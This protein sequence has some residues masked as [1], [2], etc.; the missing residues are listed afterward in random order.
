MKNIDWI[1][2]S[3]FIV[4]N[5]IKKLVCDPWFEGSVFNNG[6]D[7]LAKTKHDISIFNDIDYIWISHEHPDHFDIQ[8][9]KKIEKEVR[10]KI[11][12]IFQF[13]KDKRVINF[14]K[15]LGFKTKELKIN[16]ELSLDKNFSITIVGNYSH[17]D[18][19][20]LIKIDDIKILNLNDCAISDNN[21]IKKLKN[22]VK[23][24]DVLMMQFSYANWQGDKNNI[25]R[26]KKTASK[27]KSSLIEKC[28][29]F[30][31]NF[32]F[33]FASFVYFSH[34]ENFFQNSCTNNISEICDAINKETTSKPIVLLPGEKWNFSNKDCNESI[35]SY[36]KLQK[37]IYIKRFCTDDQKYKIDLLINE[38]RNYLKRINEKH[39]LKRSAYA[40]KKFS[41]YSKRNCNIFIKDL[42]ASFYFD[43]KNGLSPNNIGQTD[44]DI[45]LT[46]GNLF[47][48]FK[49]D[50]GADTLSV[51]GRFEIKDL[52]SRKRVFSTFSLGMKL[53][54]KKYLR[55]SYFEIFTDYLKKKKLFKKFI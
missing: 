6:W 29:I 33:P 54:T 36:S 1:N 51:N 32:F 11:T 7:L 45:S 30:K 26:M 40:L 24:V 22:Y 14:A 48:L 34:E 8:L 55:A 13:T 46:S 52:E 15:N 28:N 44:C 23:K 2:H 9:L 3:G 49:Y 37:N 38:S 5:Q 21:Q 17:H 43:L 25:V 41:E 27:I 50:W 10:E 31:P 35:N 4:D 18:S 53:V 39:L 12:F 47:Y 20:C 42:N 16:Q 19:A